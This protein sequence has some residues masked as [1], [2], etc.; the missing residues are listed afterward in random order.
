MRP[1]GLGVTES[2]TRCAVVLAI[3]V[4]VSGGI[5]SKTL[6]FNEPEGF[7]GVPWGT[8]EE[9][10][11]ARLR[12]DGAQISCGDYP[13]DGH[14]I[15]ERA[16]NGAFLLDNIRLKATYGFRAG[17]FTRVFLQF[18]SNDFNRIAAI[19]VERYG[20]STRDTANAKTWV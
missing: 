2:R 3:L 11:L 12:I 8:T 20:A 19:F 14:W 6:A 16:C 10:L 4:L 18:P 7:R 17:K 9:E 1:I 13:P 15:A 5:A